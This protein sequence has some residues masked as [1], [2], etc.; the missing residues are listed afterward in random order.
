MRRYCKERGIKFFPVYLWLCTKNL[1]KLQEFKTAYKDGKLGY[2]DTLTPL[3]P[4][5]HDDTKTVS[6]MWT[7]YS[8]SFGEFYRRY[9]DNREK[10]GENHGVLAQPDM[11]PPE[12]SYTI[13]C[14]PW[15]DFTHFAVH[16]YENKPYFFPSLEAGKIV[17]ENGRDIMPLSM[18]C[19][20][21]STDGYHVSQF[22]S[23]LQYDLD[24]IELM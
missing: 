10:Y 13:S 22:I 20:H 2:Y 24:N 17:T 7:E 18:T 21:A 4:C 5:F 12:N 6:L 19:H 3:Y 11:L 15:L 14:I 8:H 1:N 16:S 9:M 23:D